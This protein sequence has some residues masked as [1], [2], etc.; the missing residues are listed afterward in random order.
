VHHV[1]IDEKVRYYC[2][3]GPDIL[4]TYVGDIASDSGVFVLRCQY[5]INNG[6]VCISVKFV[7]C[8]IFAWPRYRRCSD[9]TLRREIPAA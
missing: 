9:T 3:A 6:A 4:F 1:V 8:L 5:P 7:A 2:I